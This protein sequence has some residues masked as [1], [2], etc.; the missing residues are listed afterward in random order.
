MAE[1]DQLRN[2]LLRRKSDSPQKQAEMRNTKTL[3]RRL[4]N[5]GSETA[6]QLVPQN[7]HE[8]RLLRIVPGKSRRPPSR[9]ER[10]KQRDYRLKKWTESTDEISTST[11]EAS[12]FLSQET[13]DKSPGPGR[14]TREEGRVRAMSNMT[15]ILTAL[16]ATSP[17]DLGAKNPVLDEKRATLKTTDSGV[18]C[19]GAMEI[20]TPP[21]P[22]PLRIVQEVQEH[23]TQY[24]P[25]AQ[26]VESPVLRETLPN[27]RQRRKVKT[28]VTGQTSKNL[29]IKGGSLWI[30]ASQLPP[31]DSSKERLMA[32]VTNVALTNKCEDYFEDSVIQQRLPL[33]HRSPKVSSDCCRRNKRFESNYKSKGYHETGEQYY[34]KYET[35]S[36]D[37]SVHYYCDNQ[38]V[39]E[40]CS[41]TYISTE[42]S[43]VSH[44]IHSPK[45]FHEAPGPS[46]LKRP[47]SNYT[48][49]HQIKTCDVSSFNGVRPGT[50]TYMCGCCEPPQQQILVV[51]DDSASTR[52]PNQLPVIYE[53]VCAECTRKS[54][55]S[56]PRYYQL[57]A[58]GNET[59]NQPPLEKAYVPSRATAAARTEKRHHHHSQGRGKH[60]RGSSMRS[61][62]STF[63]T[64]SRLGALFQCFNCLDDD[65]ETLSSGG[66]DSDN[67]DG[68]DGGDESEGYEEHGDGVSIDEDSDGGDSGSESGGDVSL[69]SAE[70]FDDQNNMF[71]I[72]NAMGEGDESDGAPNSNGSDS[73]SLTELRSRSKKGSGT[74]DDEED[75]DDFELDDDDFEDSWDSVAMY[76]RE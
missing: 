7:E 62:A 45:A 74:S 72:K 64:K 40:T 66:S 56:G 15:K 51:R 25:S 70:L 8:N 52:T 53:C 24:T 17:S 3:A 21:R 38:T 60:Y 69:N 1:W 23:K 37:L 43:T 20:E 42:Q 10:Q 14:Q 68:N 47:T 41:E 55:N 6:N 73:D 29:T 39:S 44:L 63:S 54:T 18:W 50:W 65:S 27:S 58:V 67:D 61:L 5:T 30:N 76:E 11:E 34:D 2:E 16:N 31:E 48:D 35:P 33:D 9:R 49:P 75:S 46:I 13:T 71:D 22:K 32:V 36:D 4:S 59:A 57:E 28:S 12:L 19:D 26:N